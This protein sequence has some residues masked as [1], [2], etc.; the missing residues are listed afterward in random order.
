MSLSDLIWYQKP[1]SETVGV[2]LIC[3]ETEI[4]YLPS[5]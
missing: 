1:V 4:L 5:T 2:R 3:E